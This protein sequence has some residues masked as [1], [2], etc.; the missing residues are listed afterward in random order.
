MFVNDAWEG[1]SLAVSA[2]C[3]HT[4]RADAEHCC[5]DEETGALRQR[6]RVVELQD[7]AS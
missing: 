5:A 2:S 3:R 1:M 4:I 7:V 6:D